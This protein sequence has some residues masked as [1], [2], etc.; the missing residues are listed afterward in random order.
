MHP[1]CR[2]PY[3]SG[4]TLLE[5][6]VAIAMLAI[7]LPALIN[8]VGANIRSAAHLK[9][10]TLAQWVAMNRIAELRASRVWPGEGKSSGTDSMANFDWYWEIKVS[11]TGEEDMRRLD[12]SVKRDQEEKTA[13]IS[14]EAYIGKP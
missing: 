9:E 3:G 11:N 5:V 6:L 2:K 4:F 12:V 10:R 14:I 1:N 7:A 13:I 8:A